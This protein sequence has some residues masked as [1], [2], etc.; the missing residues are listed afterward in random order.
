MSFEASLLARLQALASQGQRPVIGLN[1]PVGAGK[2]TL[3]RRLAQQAAGLGLRLA[4]ASI[5][6]AY[7]PWQPRLQAMAGNPFGVDRVPPGSHEPGVLVECIDQWRQGSQWHRDSQWHQD[8]QWCQNSQWRQNSSGHAGSQGFK[9]SPGLLRL[10]RFD[11]RLRQGAGDRC[12]FS[13]ELADG[14]L[15]EGWLIGCRPLGAGQIRAASG[16]AP[17]LAGA[18]VLS[19]AEWDWLPRW[20]QALESYQP[21]WQRLDGL[22]LLWPNDWRLP[23]RW[24]FQAEAQQRRAGGGWLSGTRLDQLVRSSLVSLPP[25]LYLQPLLAGADQVQLLDRRRRCQW[26]GP[27]R[28][29]DPSQVPLDRLGKAKPPG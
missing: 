17:S 29:F 12:G 4:V 11:K 27:G 15:L 22:W 26:Q 24:R 25:Q 20:D 14:L 28:D 10:P 3:A 5:D 2:S 1:G 16:A 21:L 13:E 19:S 9:G 18:P 6:D 23:R 8:S 7:L